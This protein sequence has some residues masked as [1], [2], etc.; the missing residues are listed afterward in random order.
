M[1]RSDPAIRNGV[2]RKNSLICGS[3]MRKI[4]YQRLKI[5]NHR[6]G[7]PSVSQSHFRF[8]EKCEISGRQ[9]RGSFLPH[10]I[11]AK[12]SKTFYFGS[13]LMFKALS[14]SGDSC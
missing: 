2:G 9:I 10:E 12:C 3:E 5:V 6:P 13:K 8:M 14:R 4:S 1:N 11:A 7:D